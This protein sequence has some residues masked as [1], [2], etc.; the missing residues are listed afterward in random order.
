MATCRLVTVF[1]ALSTSLGP[2]AEPP[3]PHRKPAAPAWGQGLERAR[4]FEARPPAPPA[5][6]SAR[7][8]PCRAGQA[9]LG[10]QVQGAPAAVVGVAQVSALPQ[11]RSRLSL[12]P[13]SAPALPGRPGPVAGWRDRRCHVRGAPGNAGLKGSLRCY[14]AAGPEHLPPEALGRRQ[15]PH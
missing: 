4:S 12:R 8:Q 7:A 11:L 6:R 10:S 2:W 14:L 1:G 15:G 3:L 5:H 13:P 9:T